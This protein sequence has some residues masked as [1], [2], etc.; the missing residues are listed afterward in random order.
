[1]RTSGGSVEIVRAF[2]RELD[3][4]AHDGAFAELEVVRHRA[5]PVRGATELRVTI[6]RRGGVD[7]ALCERV[8]ARINANL[9]AFDVPYTLEVESAGL[10]RPLLRPEHFGRFVGERARIVTSLAINGTKTHRGLL[11]GVRGE[12]VVIETE[13]G[14]L[15]LPMATIKSANLEYD[16]RAD[17]QRDKRERKKSHGN[18]RHRN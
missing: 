8:A 1:M 2:E 12:A 3:A 10:D 7:L 16:A 14:E 9:A 5:R 6:D 15:P 17:L 11:R 18:S 13:K 4:L